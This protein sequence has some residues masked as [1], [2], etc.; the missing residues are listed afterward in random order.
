MTNH[1]LLH[2]L[3]PINALDSLEGDELQ[4]VRTHLD[5]CDPCLRELTRYGGRD[6]NWLRTNP[7]PLMD[8]R[9]LPRLSERGRTCLSGRRPRSSISKRGGHGEPKPCPC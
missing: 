9:G 6:D 5:S 7:R 8:G 4:A 1:D 2:E 3:I